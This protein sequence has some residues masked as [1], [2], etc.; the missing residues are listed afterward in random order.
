MNGCQH[1]LRSHYTFVG[2]YVLKSS[3]KMYV[4]QLGGDTYVVQS[5]ARVPIMYNNVPLDRNH[6]R[7]CIWKPATCTAIMYTRRQLH[8]HVRQFM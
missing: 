2:H 3:R 5:T 7:Q 1:K 6:V 8:C 4:H